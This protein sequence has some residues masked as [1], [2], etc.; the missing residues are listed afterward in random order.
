MKNDDKSIV[1]TGDPSKGGLYQG[2]DKSESAKKI[3]AVLEKSNT[4]L[5]ESLGRPR[6]NMQNMD[7][8]VQST[9]EYFEFCCEH[10]IM[11]S[12]RRLANWYGYSYRTLY[13][14]I[15]EG[16][17]EGVFLDKIRDAI[18][19]NL[20]QAALVNAVNNISAMFILKTQHDYVEATKVV[21]EPSD[22]LL[23]Q[24]KTVE[25]IADYIDADIV[26]E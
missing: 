17:Q 3:H 19:D 15:N 18:K 24:P 8:L 9:R 1:P 25:E 12:F 7:E 23:G 20:E 22:K 10:R 14:Y 2:V 21:L 13:N 26:E 6:T 16:E 5:F 11:P 4:L